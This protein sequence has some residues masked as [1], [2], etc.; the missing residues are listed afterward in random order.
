MGT[1]KAFLRRVRRCFRRH[2]HDREL[3]DE[4]QFHL[5]LKSRR[6]Q[7]EG[8]APD[9]ARDQARRQFG[10]P[11][12][13][14]EKT[15]DLW[16]F[17]WLEDLVSDLRYGLRTLRTA[18]GFTLV[19]VLTLALG[20]GATSAIFSFVDAILFRPP[21]LADPSSLASI[22]T[23]AGNQ[24]RGL[25]SYPDFQAIES[26]GHRLVNWTAHARIPLAWTSRDQSE[27][28]WGEVASPD[29]FATL[30]VSPLLGRVFASADA[31]SP[32][33]VLEN[34]Y[35]KERW[36]ADPGVLGRA[37]QLGSRTY[38]IIG[39]MPDGFR[40]TSTMFAPAVWI[41]LGAWSGITK[42]ELYQPAR[43]WLE[44]S[45]RLA[46]GG[47]IQEA[48]AELAALSTHLPPPL[49][50]PLE[51][52][53]LVPL[54]YREMRLS[55]DRTFVFIAGIL[56][57]L[58]GIVLVIAC[59][60]VASLLLTRMV[61]RRREIALRQSLGATRSRI[62]RQLLTESLLLAGAGA[63]CGLLVAGWAL[64]LL[65]SYQIPSPE[66][67][68]LDARLDIRTLVFTIA[69]SAACSL[70]FG[71]MPALEGSRADLIGRIRQRRMARSLDL[72]VAARVAGGVVL[73]TG[74]TL[75]VAALSRAS[76]V[77]PGFAEDHALAMTVDPGLL[78]YTPAQSSN[79]SDNFSI[80]PVRLSACARRR[81]H[82][83]FLSVRA[84]PAPISGFLVTCRESFCA[85]STT[86]WTGRFSRP[87]APG[88][89]GGACSGPRILF[90]QRRL[91]LS[92][93]PS[94]DLFLQAKMPRSANGSASRSRRRSAV[95]L[96]V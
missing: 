90:L 25:S 18:P 29:Y 20:I 50:H 86:S 39:V 42:E 27:V 92:T 72:L 87:S 64:K 41:P 75:F 58:V 81:W 78:G 73:M 53:S 35:W 59:A 48:R 69:I 85:L 51:H 68:I 52:R 13:V 6:L 93:S 14:R 56:S 60:N 74:A 28:I 94:R 22:F 67:I 34:R 43:R 7:Q 70:L 79:D 23:A 16:L 30:G 77:S 38:N 21:P 24:R 5:D 55:A 80:V 2:R 54:T 19:A 17:Q 3:A 84:S 83:T 31:A 76:Q 71:L 88:S 95:R 12:L 47:P 10:N 8:I 33:V 61:G 63:V 49:E 57:V 9:D 44:I 32:S 37:M 96:W 91:P 45:A 36:G 15:R 46:P 40:G 89:C 62:I 65:T 66:P 1:N 11:T 4:I 82:R 26:A